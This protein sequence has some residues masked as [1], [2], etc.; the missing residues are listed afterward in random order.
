MEKTSN[1]VTTGR[2]L[3]TKAECSRLYTYFCNRPQN[4]HDDSH[5][6]LI[7]FAEK[8]GRT[9][10][11]VCAQLRVIKRMCTTGK[12]RAGFTH[13]SKTLREVVQQ[14]RLRKAKTI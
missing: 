10:G 9:P 4:E 1:G 2:R 13:S 5:P 3:Y 7:A 12:N 11:S 6:R 8:L 14:R